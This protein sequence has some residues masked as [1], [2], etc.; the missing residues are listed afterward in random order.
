MQVHVV[1]VALACGFKLDVQ[2]QIAL[3]LYEQPQIALGVVEQQ[4]IFQNVVPQWLQTGVAL[5]EA[6]EALVE[7]GI[8]VAF[9]DELLQLLDLGS[10]GIHDLLVLLLVV[11]E[12]R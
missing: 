3:P 11:L 10:G 12:L 7:F 1:L 6:P 9:F 8:A 2:V 4:L 5:H